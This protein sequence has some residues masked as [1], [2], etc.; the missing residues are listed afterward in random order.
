VCTPGPNSLISGTAASSLK[1]ARDGL[2]VSPVPPT[3][4]VRHLLHTPPSRQHRR[5][6]RVG[7]KPLA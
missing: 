3:G 2:E 4:H 7:R 1:S 6:T 5:H